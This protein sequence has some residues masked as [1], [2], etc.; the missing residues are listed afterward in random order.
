MFG[1]IRAA[2]VLI[3]VTPIAEL[4]LCRFFGLGVGLRHALALEKGDS[5]LAN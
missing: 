5:G 4:G 2:A 1:N 3:G